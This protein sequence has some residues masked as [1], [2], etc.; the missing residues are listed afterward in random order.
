MEKNGFALIDLVM[1]I[2]ILAIL[3]FSLFGK[4]VIGKI[5]DNQRK[6]DLE[7][8]VKALEQYKNDAGEYPDSPLPNCGQPLEK[9]INGT[10]RAYMN[11]TPCDPWENTP[12]GYGVEQ[13]GT[14]NH[15]FALGAILERYKKKDNN[16][17]KN[18]LCD[19]LD[20]NYCISSH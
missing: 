19:G 10:V 1:I 16:K 15:T 7:N 8:I 9:I 6:S 13:I 4:G 14:F 3:T 11:K 2:T 18:L 5:R 20:C 12:Y 17:C